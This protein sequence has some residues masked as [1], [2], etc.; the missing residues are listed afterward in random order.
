[1]KARDIILSKERIE[2]IREGARRVSTTDLSTPVDI[3][4]FQED[5]LQTQA[6][7]AFNAGVRE[8][9]DWIKTKAWQGHKPIGFDPSRGYLI[10]EEELEA[11]LKEEK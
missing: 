4:I 9:L 1:M 8:M 11:K 2:Q 3:R 6:E 7:I 5:L 10:R